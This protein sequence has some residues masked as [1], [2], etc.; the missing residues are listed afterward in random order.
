MKVY[1]MAA[2]AQWRKN[3]AVGGGWRANLL[4]MNRNTKVVVTSS[5]IF[6]CVPV[7]EGQ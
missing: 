7:C 3:A 1:V 4:L 5:D 6:N 2:G